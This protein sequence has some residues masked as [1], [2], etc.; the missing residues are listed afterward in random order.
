MDTAETRRQDRIMT[1]ASKVVRSAPRRE[2]L[3]SGRRP[4]QLSDV[5]SGHRSGRTRG[6]AA[7]TAPLA[8]GIASRSS[9]RMPPSSCSDGWG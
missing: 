1:G 5:R 3:R 9:C 7:S 6:A 4:E 2:Q 8:G